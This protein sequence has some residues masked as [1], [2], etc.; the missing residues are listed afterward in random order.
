MDE[1]RRMEGFR[2]LIASDKSGSYLLEEPDGNWSHWG[3]LSA[4]GK[5]HYIARAAAMYDVPFEQFAATARAELG[6][7]EAVTQA[8]LRAA[9]DY[10]KELHGLAKLV[11]SDWRTE[12]T[13]LVERFQEILDYKPPER[14]GL[15]AHDTAERVKTQLESFLREFERLAE[16]REQKELV[17]AFKDFIADVTNAGMKETFDKLLARYAQGERQTP[18]SG[19]TRSIEW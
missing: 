15:L 4:E 17:A 12:P 5:L 6:D 2:K 16:T 19:R 10:K 8:A 9:L 3:G 11:P 18:E 1:Q 7:A 14:A 13:P